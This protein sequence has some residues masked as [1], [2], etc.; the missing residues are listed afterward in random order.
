M[1]SSCNS[2]LQGE[3]GLS[4]MHIFIV[5]HHANST[6]HEVS[7]VTFVKAFTLQKQVAEAF[8]VTHTISKV[9]RRFYI[10]NFT[11]NAMFCH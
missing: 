5:Q 4:K 11:L 2:W 10:L 8:L 9:E 1:T 7:L 6:C 3:T